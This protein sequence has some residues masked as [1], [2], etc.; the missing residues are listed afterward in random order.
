MAIVVWYSLNVQKKLLWSTLLEILTRYPEHFVDFL[1]ASMLKLDMRA[2]SHRRYLLNFG[3]F[4]QTYTILV[5]IVAP[6]YS[7]DIR[8]FSA[9]YSNLDDT[10]SVWTSVWF[11]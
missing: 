5:R 7:V 8:L 11:A 3:L 6:H 10:A 2:S 4:Y 1:A 9:R